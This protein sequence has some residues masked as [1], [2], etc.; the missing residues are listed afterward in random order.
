MLLPYRITLRSRS[1]ASPSGSSASVRT[2]PANAAG[3][4]RGT[5]LSID[6]YRFLDFAARQVMSD[7]Y[8]HDHYPLP[9][10]VVGGGC[11]ALCGGGHVRC[12]ERTPLSNLLLTLIRRAGVPAASLGDS[13]GECAGI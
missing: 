5:A 10:A 11:G 9:L 3:L 13:T 12:E 6:S 4:V 7:S 2:N 1:D 8:R